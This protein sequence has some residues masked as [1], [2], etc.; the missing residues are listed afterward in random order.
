MAV[1]GFLALPFASVKDWFVFAL[2]TGV[3]ILAGHSVGM[4]RLLIH[5]SFKTFPS[6]ATG[7]WQDAW[8]QLHCTLPSSPESALIGVEAHQS[9]PGYRFIRLLE[10]AGIVWDVELPDDTPKR[11]GLI[12]LS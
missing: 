8:W 12:V 7:F 6:H 1:I 9:D 3:T 10:A 4:H 11:E 5:R 2:L